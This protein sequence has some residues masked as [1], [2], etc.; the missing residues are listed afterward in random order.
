M[1]VVLYT[2][3]FGDNGDKL[4]QPLSQPSGVKLVAFMDRVPA[5]KSHIK[6][7]EIRPPT[8]ERPNK[9]RQARQHKCL[10][11]LLFPEATHSLWV[12]GCYRPRHNALDMVEML[13]SENDLCMFEHADRN[14]IYQEVEAC[15]R[16]RKDDPG[17]M[18]AQADRYR[19][20]N[21]PYNNSLAET[22]AVLRRHTD[23]IAQ[24][25]EMWWEEIRAGSQRDQLSI[26]YVCWRLGVK[27]SHFEGSR[28]SNPHFQWYPHKKT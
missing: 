9:R 3:I 21:Y 15:I 23:Q 17:I 13:L 18:R 16:Y 22:T 12:D 1:K 24:V 4:Y 27:Y 26:D 20:E 6:G 5:G 10:P 28:P 25:N 19:K 7:W 11:H 8:W 2:A 14:C